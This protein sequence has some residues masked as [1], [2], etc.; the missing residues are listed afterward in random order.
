MLRR[1]S[2]A[3]MLLL[4]GLALADATASLSTC[5][6]D[7]TTGK[8]R[9]D[10]ARWVFFAMSSHPDLKQFTSPA[11]DAAREGTDHAIADLFSSLITD[12]CHAEAAASYQ[13]G[14]PAS[15]ATAF[16]AL[17]R[18]AMM[19]LMANPDT[20]ATMTAFNRF[21]DQAKIAET[22]NRK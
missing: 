4:P 9:K 2:V 10:L 6:S 19:E 20:N 11:L 21:L 17:G 5:V 15:F 14:G 13:A 1:L 7:S 18:L 22:L 12:R 3:L 8:E 16:E